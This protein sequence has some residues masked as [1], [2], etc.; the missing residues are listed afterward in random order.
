[1]PRRKPPKHDESFTDAKAPGADDATKA[2]SPK[3]PGSAS[4]A[5]PNLPVPSF[6]ASPDIALPGVKGMPVSFFVFL[7]IVGVVVVGVLITVTIRLIQAAVL[8]AK[9][10][11]YNCSSGGCV[12]YGRFLVEGVR[13]DVH[14]CDDLYKHV[15]G[16]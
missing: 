10:E 16:K 5:S 9:P 7:L 1:M 3:S 4:K 6:V 11:A 13:D 12:V 14:P 15:C 8:P 2:K